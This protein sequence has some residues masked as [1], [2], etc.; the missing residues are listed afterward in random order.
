M[1]RTIQSV[2]E[3]YTDEI[4]D[5]GGGVFEV[6]FHMRVIFVGEDPIGEWHWYGTPVMGEGIQHSATHFPFA[7]TQMPD[8]PT[9]LYDLAVGAERAALEA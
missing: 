4:V 1:A 9:L 8:T 7:L 6:S 2:P 3:L 5:L